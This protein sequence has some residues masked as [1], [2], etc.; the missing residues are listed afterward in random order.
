MEVTLRRDLDPDTDFYYREQFKIYREPYLLWE[1]EIWEAIL[2]TCDAYRIEVHGR[3]AGDVILEERGKGTRYITDFSLLPE[4][5][6]R[7]VGK[8]ALTEIEKMVRR[9]TAVTRKETLQ[10][11]VKSGFVLKR[12]LKNYYCY[13]VD[14]YYIEYNNLR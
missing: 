11:F 12:R 3:Y 8:A 7:G 10:F 5:Q 4:Y 9:L 6:G 13:G 1:K 2:S 14:G